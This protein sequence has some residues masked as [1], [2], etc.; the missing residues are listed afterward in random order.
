MRMLFKHTGQ[1]F[2][3][4]KGD[5]YLM[6]GFA[7][8]TETGEKMVVYQALYDDCEMYVRP[9]DMFAEEVPKNKANPTGQKYRFE[10]HRVLSEVE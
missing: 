8:H 1:I 5:L 10:L 7:Q 3:H 4:F 9:Y 6:L 2:R